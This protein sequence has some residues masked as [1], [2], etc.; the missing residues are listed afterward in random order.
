[1]CEPDSTVTINSRAHPNDPLLKTQPAVVM[2]N[3]TGAW[4]ASAY[5][6]HKV[7]VCMVD[8]GT[9]L[10]NRDLTSNLW[11][12]VFSSDPHSRLVLA[13]WPTC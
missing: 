4:K 13:W 6:S 12:Y 9:D 8:T 3:A 1:M 7:V 10:Y 11:R 2:V 5:G